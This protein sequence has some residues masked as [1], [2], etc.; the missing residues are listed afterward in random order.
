MDDPAFYVEIERGL[1]P[2][3]RTKSIRGDDAQWDEHIMLLVSLIY[4][5]HV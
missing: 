3:L 5:L 1:D 4:S 2:H